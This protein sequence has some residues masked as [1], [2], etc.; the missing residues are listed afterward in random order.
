MDE[1]MVCYKGVYCLVRQYVPSKLIKCGL[2]MWALVDAKAWYVFNFDINYVKN[3][4]MP[5]VK[6]TNKGEPQVGL[7]VV[8]QLVKGVREFRS[9]GCH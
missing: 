7:K 8:K 6:V 2:K 3:K 4:S 9:C 1:M 5:S